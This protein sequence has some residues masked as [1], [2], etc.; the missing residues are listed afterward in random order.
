Q[1]GERFVGHTLAVSELYVSLIERTRVDGYRVNEFLAEPAAWW[2]NGVGGWM[3]PDAYVAL[4]TADVTDHWWIEVDLATEA[5]PTLRGKFLA[6]TD[7]ANRGQLGPSQVVPR[8]L[9]T[10]PS[11][12]RHQTMR[13]VVAGLP[14]PGEHLVCVVLHET[15]VDTLSAS[16][17]AADDVPTMS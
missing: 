13:H 9:V 15:A 11:E 17:L 5:V 7:F 1:P 4:S 14:A 6:Y 3:K 10:V 16:L 12:Y 8:V 2:P